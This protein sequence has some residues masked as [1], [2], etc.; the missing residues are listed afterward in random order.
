M[1]NK[2]HLVSK[3]T[4]DNY[5]AVIQ[6][7]LQNISTKMSEFNREMS[8]LA[9]ESQA[10]DERLDRIQQPLQATEAQVRKFNNKL[11]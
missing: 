10:K 6:E 2:E 9:C 8:E 5:T 4:N 1:F 7:Q 11:P 3:N